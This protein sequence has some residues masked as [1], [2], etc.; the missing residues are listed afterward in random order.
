MRQGRSLSG[1]LAVSAG[2]Q[3]RRSRDRG[4]PPLPTPAWLSLLPLNLRWRPLTIFQTKGPL[5]SCLELG[6]IE[7]K[8]Q[9]DW[10]DLASGDA[11][12]LRLEDYAKKVRKNYQTLR[13][14]RRVVRA[15]PAGVRTPLHAVMTVP[16]AKRQ[17]WLQWASEQNGRARIQA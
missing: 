12:E 10:G 4:V 14:Y 1:G 9:W 3:Q 16:P 2:P 11:Q 5:Y 6:R 17:G 8:C 13:S 7:D 15:F